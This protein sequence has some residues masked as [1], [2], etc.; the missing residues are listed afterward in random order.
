MWWKT[1]NLCNLPICLS[2]AFVQ[3][4]NESF[5]SFQ[6]RCSLNQE[7][8]V[9]SISEPL[10]VD[11]FWKNIFK[12]D[13]NGFLLKSFLEINSIKI[14]FNL[15]DFLYKI[16]KFLSF[17]PSISFRMLVTI[18]CDPPNLSS[19]ASIMPLQSPNLNLLMRCWC[20]L[21]MACSNLRDTSLGSQLGTT[22]FSNFLLNVAKSLESPENVI[23]WAFSSLIGQTPAWLA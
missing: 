23:F 2:V 21:G 20:F 9:L 10:L 5:A 6:S 7:I 3:K 4:F 13:K 18:L 22:T 8:I 14:F 12:L 11:G 15:L 16:K 19:R 1:F 17:S